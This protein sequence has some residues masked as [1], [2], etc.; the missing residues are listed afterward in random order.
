VLY[1]KKFGFVT[2]EVVGVNQLLISIQKYLF[3]T[4]Q[5]RCSSAL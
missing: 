2:D 4:T 1:V 5:Q 3:A